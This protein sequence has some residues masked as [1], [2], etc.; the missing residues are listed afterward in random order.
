MIS[1]NSNLEFLNKFKIKQSGLLSKFS[2]TH[3]RLE[4]SGFVENA[5]VW[6]SVGEVGVVEE[7][8]WGEVETGGTL[9]R[10]TGRNFSGFNWFWPIGF[11]RGSFITG[12]L[13]R[14]ESGL[15]I[16]R[17]RRTDD[18]VG[19]GTETE[20]VGGSERRSTI[21]LGRWRRSDRLISTAST[22]QFLEAWKQYFFKM[23]KNGMRHFKIFTQISTSKDLVTK[24]MMKIWFSTLSFHS[25]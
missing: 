18:T 16:E 5:W 3:C 23:L 12:W 11:N 1:D 24:K 7:R 20:S 17:R 10:R 19:A 2:K 15:Q 14:E 22:R 21:G 8:R 25:L 13:E 6:K 4:T 9:E